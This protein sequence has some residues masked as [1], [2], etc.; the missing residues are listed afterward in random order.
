MRVFKI[1]LFIILT[2]MR[3]GAKKSGDCTEMKRLSTSI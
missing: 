2:I 1:D 3:S